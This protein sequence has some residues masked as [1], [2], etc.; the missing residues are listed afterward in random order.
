[1]IAIAGD[2][3]SSLIDSEALEELNPYT[4]FAAAA[5]YIGRLVNPGQL[6]SVVGSAIT[7]AIAERGP[8]VI[9]MPGDVAS[10]DAPPGAHYVPLPA[11]TIGLRLRRRSRGHG[12]PDQPGDDGGHLRRRRMQ[13]R[14]RGDP[15]SRPEA[16]GAPVGYSHQ[17][18]AVA[19]ARQPQRRGHDRAP[20]LR[21]LLGRHQ[22]RR[23]AAH[24][25]HRLPLL[26]LPPSQ[27]RQD[28]SGR[29]GP[30]S[31]RAAACR[32]NSAWSGT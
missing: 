7:T 15:C 21:R 30:P 19:R 5:L 18:Q 1:M 14:P 13:G 27:G 29:P 6:H 8:T 17:G 4:F 26:R 16:Q 23:R 9:S 10:A 2:V 24:A 31:P 11:A 25:G 28:H 32:S 22:P 3:E 20:R 12:R